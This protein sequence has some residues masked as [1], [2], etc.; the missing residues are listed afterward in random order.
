MVCTRKKRQ[1]NRRLLSQLDDF[2]QDM[3]TSNAA[4]ERQE[5]IVLDEGSNDRVFTVG[6]SSKNKA[7][8]E[9]TVNVKIL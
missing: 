6:F 8:N 1:S 2:D 7:I 5:N 9:R 4:S 3:V